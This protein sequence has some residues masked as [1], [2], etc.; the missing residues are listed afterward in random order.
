MQTSERRNP[1]ARFRR[2]FRL[3]YLSAYF[4]PSARSFAGLKAAS[5]NLGPSAFRA[6]PA[7]PLIRFF[8]HLIRDSLMRRGLLLLLLLSRC[9]L[10]ARETP[11]IAPR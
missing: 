4:R 10:S 1:F 7:L 3:T 11:I 8:R 6:G 9:A 5:L 2:H